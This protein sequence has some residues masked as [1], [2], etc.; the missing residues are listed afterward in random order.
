[1]NDRTKVLLPLQVVIVLAAASVCFSGASGKVVINEIMY[2]PDR[3]QGSDEYFEWVELYNAG[4]GAEDLSGWKLVDQDPTHDP[5][6]F[7][8]STRLEAGD[9]LVVCGNASYVRYY[10][11]ISNYIGN[12][13]GRFALGNNDDVVI[14]KDA[15]ENVVDE[16]HYNDA[17]PW[18][19]QADGDGSSLERVSPLGDSADPHNWAASVPTKDYGTPGKKNSLFMDGSAPLV[20]INE[21]HYHP[22]S[23]GDEEE[24][25]ELYNASGSGVNLTGWEFD[26]GVFFT[27]LA[28][29]TIPS[30]DYLVV[31]SNPEWVKANYG[32][33]NVVGGT[34][35]EE[36]FGA[37]DNGGETIVLKDAAGR[38]VD[39]VAYSDSANRYWPL[40]A[41]GYG[42]SLE[43]INPDRPNH[44]AGNWTSGVIE[45]RWVQ[46]ETSAASAT[47]DVLYFYLNGEGEV[48]IDD[49]S[50]VPG[51]GGENLIANGDLEAGEAGWVKLGNHST[52][53]RIQTEAHS[54]TGC[55]KIVSTGDG[56]GGEW[57]NYLG[58]SVPG[59]VMGGQY[60]LSLWAK[61]V[62]GESRLT[63]RLANSRSTEGVCA[64]VDLAREGFACTPGAPNT[65][66][67]ENFP[68]FIYHVRAT[69]SLPT[70]D[71]PVGI[72]ATITARV[73]DMGQDG[74]QT[75]ESI[76]S[77]R[78]EYKVGDEWVSVEMYDDGLHGD[79]AAG[80]GE[81]GAE[82]PPLP[83]FTV[84]RYRV[85]AEDDGG[86]VSISPDADEM[87]D[88]HAYFTYDGECYG[89]EGV[90]A[91]PVYDLFV[92]EQHL[93][94]LEQL[95]TRDDYVP[96][97]LVY[98]GEV[99]DDI[100][101][102]WYGSFSERM[103]NRKRNWRI[104]LNPWE[105]IQRENVYDLDSLILL[106][107]DY[108]DRD[109]R[110]S[111]GLREVMTQRMFRYAGCAY[112]EMEYVLLRLNGADY[113]L[114]LRVERPDTDYLERNGR[115][116]EGDL[117]QAQSFPG[118][119]PS[120]LSV[121]SSYDDYV[122]AYDRKTNRIQ[123]HEGLTTLIEELEST[124]DEAIEDF[125]NERVNVAKYA[126]YLAASAF[127]QSWVSPSR[128]YY[129]FF[130]KYL[131]ASEERYLWELMPWGGENN[132]GRV[133]LPP[134]NGIVGETAYYLPN[135]MRTR[136]LNN[137]VFRQQFVDRLRQ[138]LD[139]IY[140]EFH[141]SFLV[142]QISS[143]IE[144]AAD[145]DRSMWWPE[146]P[147]LAEQAAALKNNMIA[148]R[149]FLYNWLDEI[150]GPNQPSNVSPAGG[151][152]HLSWPI[153]LVGSEFAGIPGSVHQ[154]SQWQVREAT[155]MY[156]SALYDS[157]EDDLNLTTISV[158]AP[159]GPTE[160]T[161][162][163]RVRYKDDGDRWSLWSDESGFSTYGDTVPPSIVS[164]YTLPESQGEIL[165]V[166]GEPVDATTAE[167]T[168][169]Y[170]INGSEAPDGASLSGDGLTVTLT[171]PA[172]LSLVSLTVSNVTDLADP[173]NVI[174]PDTEVPIQTWVS[175]KAKVNFQPDL[176]PIPAGY[177]KDSGSPFDSGR[178]YGWTTDVT[179][180]AWVRNIQADERLDTLLS[181]G[182]E[183]S[184]WELAVSSPGRY[185]VTAVLGDAASDSM[186]D[187][188]VEGNWVVSGLY[189]P[190][191]EFQEVTA[192][193]E[194][195][196][197]RLTLS[198][199]SMYR[200][201]RIVYLHV[202]SSERSLAVI[203]MAANASEPDFLD[204]TWD[205]SAGSSYRIHW[206]QEL[207]S[208]N[209]VAPDA[210]DMTVDEQGGTVTWT[211]KG[212]SPGMAGVPPGQA[213]QR[214]YRVELVG[215]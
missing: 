20:V 82:V 21:I 8:Q 27:F 205:N 125:F 108:D 212:T 210:G 95:G 179:D 41:D 147:S 110:G 199:G 104:R 70:G 32:I 98:E 116:V 208:W 143:G 94:R 161:F 71:D 158:P 191:N 169:N 102:R 114:M 101:V 11:S 84:V 36:L 144:E 124:G 163:W 43:C 33:E 106:G 133:S 17:Y 78:A 79:D 185:R 135:M 193:V 61:P 4:S 118:Q 5:F 190:A 99:Y 126:S 130:G 57:R 178:G 109:L 1:M 34:V 157:G 76:S 58:I 122:F 24:Y 168:S 211:D 153:T 48:L 42:P 155:G 188:A 92:E 60:V 30:N 171:V 105:D 13:A 39:F 40:R 56:G 19:F 112:A 97:T 177:V 131:V 207:P 160:G 62:S 90:P 59:I 162:F 51:E 189:L 180:L 87:K 137:P 66:Y 44:D 209:I 37:L 184:A 54:G 141:L 165:V 202:L 2:N 182:G 100:G 166:F 197:G 73:V 127:A 65:S 115:D 22:S 150:E 67:R 53:T 86:A 3:L 38:V 194:G 23:G 25:I 121:L 6:V 201:T 63:A 120:N 55:M 186:Y 139:T 132:W 123:P 89:E 119:P 203:G 52:S 83:C 72:G 103:T 74:K 146:S 140:T 68:P 107:G 75:L 46:V 49:V 117:F 164:V 173:S 142:D 175:Y 187:L 50:L 64:A 152:Q 28:G 148:R 35:P 77:V 183:N 149:E 198:G 136:F 145:A 88:T 151:S 85:V 213:P 9:Y 15:S 69:L 14:L 80:D 26:R 47:G 159:P 128:D 172:G 195:E 176:E 134:L 174:E 91:L 129:L 45:R 29:T 214:F 16:V 156:S 96:G 18:P 31:C 196:D 181:F 206:C 167:E 204:I 93:E 154:A 10:Y 81:Y 170:A 138:L 12:F 111:A 113:G 200:G 192:E 7:P 215:Q